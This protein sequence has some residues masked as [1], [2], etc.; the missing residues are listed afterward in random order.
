MCHLSRYVTGS[1]MEEAPGG[2]LDP[3]LHLRQTEVIGLR[4][5]PGHAGH[6]G[7]PLTTHPL[8]SLTLDSWKCNGY[9]QDTW[10]EATRD[11]LS[12]RVLWPDK[13]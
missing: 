3:A 9:F 4:V 10:M 5:H 7:D 1:A 11:S 6:T 13:R 8:A 12:I 2:K